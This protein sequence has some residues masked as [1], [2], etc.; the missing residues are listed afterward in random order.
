MRPAVLSSLTGPRVLTWTRGWR[1]AT[2]G[3]SYSGRW[4]RRWVLDELQASSL[5]GMSVVCPVFWWQVGRVLGWGLRNRG[6][7]NPSRAGRSETNRTSTRELAWTSVIHLSNSE[8]T[9]VTPS[10]GVLLPVS[11]R[12]E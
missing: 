2:E 12:I 8:K 1:R 11:Y 6:S 4:V 10:T 7:R 5:V 3:T 9:K